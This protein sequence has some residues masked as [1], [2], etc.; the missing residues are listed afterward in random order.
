MKVTVLSFEEMRFS[1]RGE[2][3]HCATNSVFMIV[4]VPH[5][6]ASPRARYGD[7][8]RVAISAMKCQGCLQYILGIV[9]FDF[10]QNRAE[11]CGHYPI[12]SPDDKVP[13]G[14]PSNIGAGYSEALRCK[15]VKAY[16]ATVLMCRRALQVSCD[17]E[18]A[19]GNDLFKQIDDLAS[20]QRIT[21][22]LRKMAHRIR[23]LGKK[24][25]HG[26]YSDIDDT[27]T[28][29]DAS[30]AVLFMHHYLERFPRSCI[31]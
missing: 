30:D 10:L 5:M 31:R 14:I 20:K 4:G 21:E 27:I 25:A 28:E 6:Q 9:D 3:P 24:G 22:P 8:I 11:Y 18:K 29:K 12:G 16:S 19:E 15:H 23:L 2:C 13:D 7:N 1:L 17:T 26:D